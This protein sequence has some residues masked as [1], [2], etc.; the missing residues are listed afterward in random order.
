MTAHWVRLPWDFIDRVAHRFLNEVSGVSRV[1]YN[2]S[3]K[4]PAAIEWE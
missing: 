2:V 3:G 4:P 1:V